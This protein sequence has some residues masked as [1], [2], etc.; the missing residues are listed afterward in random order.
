[1]PL[2]SLICTDCGNSYETFAHADERLGLRSECCG[3]GV[4]SDWSKGAPSV[5]REWHGRE[6]VNLG[7]ALDPS[8]IAEI[9]RECP[10][11]EL[12]PRTGNLISRNDAQNRRQ[13]KQLQKWHDRLEAKDK[14]AREP[15]I[16]AQEAAKK[17]ATQK[18][19][20]ICDGFI[21]A[22]RGRRVS[23]A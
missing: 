7:V 22:N 14:A 12:H 10:D 13:L 2:Y 15:E 5:Q 9:K 8:N 18:V 3:A 20:E 19:E 1:M 16:K 23:A 17:E 4:E 11:V 6:R 21:R